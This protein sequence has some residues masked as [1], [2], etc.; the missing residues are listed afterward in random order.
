MTVRSQNF[1]FVKDTY[2]DGEKLARNDRKTATYY[3]ASFLPHYRRVLFSHLLVFNLWP[4][5]LFYW[6]DCTSRSKFL[7]HTLT[8]LYP[9]HWWSGIHYGFLACQKSTVA[10]LNVSRPTKIHLIALDAFE[11][12]GSQSKPQKGSTFIYDHCWPSLTYICPCKIPSQGRVPP[13]SPLQVIT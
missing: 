2:V 7:T 10:T 4:R 6:T 3:A 12:A 1:S 11:S 9:A 13:P 8:N 5:A